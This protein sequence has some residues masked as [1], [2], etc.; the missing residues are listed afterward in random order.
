MTSSWFQH[1]MSFQQRFAV[2]SSH[3][4]RSSDRIG[5]CYSD[6]RLVTM[7]QRYGSLNGPP[8]ALYLQPMGMAPAAP[9]YQ[10]WN[11]GQ[12]FSQFDTDGD[13]VLDMSEFQRAFRALGLKKRSGAKMEIDGAMFKSFDTNGDGKISIE[14]VWPRSSHATH[15]LQSLPPCSSPPLL[16]SSDP[17]VRLDP[18]SV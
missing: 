16:L 6:P 11:L 5:E 18:P 15:P 8:S 9:A 12:I 13:G 2:P 10:R 1:N 7:T 4:A 14:E 3:Y 17:H